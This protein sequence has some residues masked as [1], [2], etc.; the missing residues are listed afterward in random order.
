MGGQADAQ[1]HSRHDRRGRAGV[2]VE[3][4]KSR[5]A[6]LAGEVNLPHHVVRRHRDAGRRGP[7][8]RIQRHP[9]L[10]QLHLVSD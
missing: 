6:E 5:R 2:E 3:D 10:D 4:R 9:A 8:A 1:P 7:D